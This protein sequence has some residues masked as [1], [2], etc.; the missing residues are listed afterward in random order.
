VGRKA[1]SARLRLAAYSRNKSRP[2]EYRDVLNAALA[3]PVEK[4]VK[5]HGRVE[6]TAKLR[7]LW[8]R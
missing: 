3:L 6:D 4:R 1:P 5:R 8:D 7:Y 2:E